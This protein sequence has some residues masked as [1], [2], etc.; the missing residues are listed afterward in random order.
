MCQVR[1]KRSVPGTFMSFKGTCMFEFLQY[2]M[3]G[4]CCKHGA[5]L[6]RAVSRRNVRGKFL[7]TTLGL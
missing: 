5:F 7:L 3:R 4:T 6:N 1:N 2:S